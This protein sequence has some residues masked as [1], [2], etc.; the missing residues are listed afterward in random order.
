MTRFTG[1]PTKPHGDAEAH[2]R[3]ALPLFGS[4]AGF[5]Q[6]GLAIPWLRP[7][8]VYQDAAD[9]PVEVHRPQAVGILAGVGIELR[10]GA[11]TRAVETS[12]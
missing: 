7:R 12:P 9:A 1:S 3:L 8:F 2:V 10:A 11:G 4:L 6:L 5:A